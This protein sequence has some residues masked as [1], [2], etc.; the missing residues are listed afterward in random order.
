MTRVFDLLNLQAKNYPQ[1]DALSFKAGNTVVKYSTNDIIHY[2]DKLGLG[3]IKRGIEK[4]DRIAIISKN[5]PEWVMVD[6]GI[7]KAGGIS[8][9]VSPNLPD[10]DLVFILEQCQV[11]LIF[12]SGKNTWSRIKGLVKK[13]SFIK[14]AYSF[15][16]LDDIQ[17]W[18]ILTNESINEKNN[19]A[20]LV[21]N[22]IQ[23]DDVV[24]IIY[25]YNNQGLLKG[26][27]LTHQNF[28][29]TIISLQNRL[30]IPPHARALSFLPLTRIFERVMQYYYIAQG[31]KIFFISEEDSIIETMQS[32]KPEYCTM[33][34]RFLEKIYNRILWEGQQLKGLRKELFFK[35]IELARNFKVDKYH[36]WWYAVKL[37]FYRKLI[38]QAWKEAFGGE[39]KAIF[40]SSALMDEKLT[41]VFWA[42]DIPVIGGYGLTETTSLLAI[43]DFDRIKVKPATYGKPLE[44]VEIR[45]SKEGEVLARGKQIMKG[46]YLEPQLTSEVIDKDGWLC[47]GD[48]GEVSSDGYLSVIGKKNDMI[49]LAGDIQVSP[50]KIE[51]KLLESLFID[52]ALIIGEGQRFIA[53]LIVPDYQIL[54]EWC[55]IQKI[56]YEHDQ[57]LV[58]HPRVVEKFKREIEICNLD[59]QNYEKV[60]RFELMA[61]LWT[62]ESNELT[63]GFKKKRQVIMDNNQALI[64]AMFI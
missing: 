5:R 28:L 1:E 13:L 32:Y 54:K 31:A 42:A 52:Q 26:V 7:Q 44:G 57:D 12:V 50:R 16:R 30:S 59:L 2:S 19:I 62:F 53:A 61:K 3:L 60:K 18:S 55:A 29:G 40:T 36:H 6:F 58:F 41:R 48:I 33:K 15:Q 24:S 22:A 9:P 63:P 25:K 8:V 23:P 37:S 56:S 38:F 4:G 43:H 45:I 47:T 20:A 39:L 51:V 49:R 64:E 34:P 10:D 46:Y 17:H 35:A 21:S 27:M 14:Y 11:K